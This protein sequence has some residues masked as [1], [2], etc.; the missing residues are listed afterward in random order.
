VGD[1]E[2]SAKVPAGAKNVTLTLELKA[3]KAKLQ[4]WLID[5]GKSTSRG[6]FYV[7]VRRVK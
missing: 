3:G 7:T 2:S 6:A 1:V 5:E 4:T